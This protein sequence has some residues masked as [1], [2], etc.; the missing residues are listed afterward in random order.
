MLTAKFVFYDVGGPGVSGD[1]GST[2]PSSG[3]VVP[4]RTRILE[5]DDLEY[6]KVIMEPDQS[7]TDHVNALCPIIELNPE[8]FEKKKKEPTETFIL[9]VRN[10]LDD[11][12]YYMATDCQLYIMNSKGSTIESC[13]CS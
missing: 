12:V 10:G 1:D 9:A 6:K 13:R 4:S 11:L 7:W 5:G 8:T 3:K 2:H